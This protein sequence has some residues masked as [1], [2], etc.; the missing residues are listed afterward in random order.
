LT[1]YLIIKN[2]Q[3]HGYLGDMYDAL[4]SAFLII[5]CADLAVMGYLYRSYFGRSILHEMTPDSEKKEDWYYDT[6]THTYSNHLP[7]EAQLAQDL[8]KKKA[9]A[10]YNLKLNSLKEEVKQIK[11]EKLSQKR[12][13][14]II[15]DKNRTRAAVK[16]Q[17]WWRKHLYEPGQGVF[18]LRAQQNFTQLSS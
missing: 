10:E 15:D 11:Q 8:E 17:Q 12:T 16:I 1:I 18:F 14:K 9:L 13:G 5:L 3:I 2:L 7:L 6:E 4:Y